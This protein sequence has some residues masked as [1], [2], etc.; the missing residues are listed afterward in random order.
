MLTSILLPVYNG[1]NYI[2]DS[3]KSILK[4]NGNWELIIQDDC[5]TDNTEQI[6]R[7]YLSENISYYK[8]ESSLKCWGTLNESAIHAR[9]SLLRLFSHDDIMLYDDI[10]VNEQYMRNNPDIGL[11]FTNYDMIDEKGLVTGSSLDY[12]ERNNDLMEKISGNT[13]ALKLYKWGCISGSQSNVTLRK[14]VYEK[15]DH[16]DANMLY[17]GDFD[18]LSRAGIKFG[19]GYN[20]KKTCQIRFHPLQTSAEGARAHTKIKEM[21]IIINYLLSHMS[22]SERQ[23]CEKNFSRIYGYLIK[24]PLK[25]AAKGNIKPIQ[26]FIKSFGYKKAI[27][28]ILGVYFRK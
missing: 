23:E 3:I 8:N 18:L 7:K 24:Q 22:V 27:D 15:I 17:T 6:C 19:I 28:S 14:E 20:S 21:S 25:Q 2:E 26:L 4:Q 10:V 13:A 16:F 5:S 11:S 1:A 12:V 9:G